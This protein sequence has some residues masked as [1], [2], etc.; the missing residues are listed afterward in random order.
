MST[1]TPLPSSQCRYLLDSLS[2]YVDGTLQE[3]LCLE[4][5]RHLAECDNCRVVVDTLRR[6]VYLVQ[7]LEQAQPTLPSDVRVRLFH[8]L[9]LDEFLEGDTVEGHNAEIAER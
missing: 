5:E 9:Q 8:K 4:I 2:E 3:S 7:T 1:S 6:T